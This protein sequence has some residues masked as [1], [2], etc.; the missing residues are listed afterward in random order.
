MDVIYERRRPRESFVSYQL[1]GVDAAVRF[2]ESDV[3]LAR[4][5]SESLINRHG[6]EITAQVLFAFQ[7]LEQCFEV[8]GTEALGAFTLDYLVKE[9]RSVFHR[10]GENLQQVSFLVPVDEN[11]E[12]AQPCDVFVGVT[13]GGENRVVISPRN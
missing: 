1:L 4:D 13:N 8:A 6:L 12:G 7:R 2:P 5:L 9:R 10:L 3:A 11:A